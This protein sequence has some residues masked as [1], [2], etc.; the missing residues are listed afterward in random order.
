VKIIPGS[1]V[2]FACILAGCSLEKKA[3]KTA[4]QTVKKADKTPEKFFVK[5]ATSKGDFVIETVREWAPRG[6]DRF[7]ELVTDGFYDGSRFFRVRPNFVVQFGISKD[8]KLNELW[9]QLQ[10]PDDPVKQSN[11]RG[12]LS[13]ATR[14]P[15]TRTT[16][17]FINLRDNSNLDSRGFAPFGRVVEGLDIVEK[18][19]AGYGEVAA[20]GGNGPDAAK[21]ESM[22][23]E[24]AH[25]SFPRLDKI[26]SAKVIEYKQ[27]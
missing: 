26:E 11:R 22:G 3:E 27:P 23:D 8:P 9:R 1:V 4:E 21:L 14:G 13:F 17:V 15:G 20:L 25:R 12:Y 19:Y 24:Y 7:Y 18:L 10:L 2:V 5:L 16:Q 6:A